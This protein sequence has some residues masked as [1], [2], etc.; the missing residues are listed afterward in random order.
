MI[1]Q[2]NK[3]HIVQLLNRTSFTLFS[4]NHQT[5]FSEQPHSYQLTH[6]RCPPLEFSII[7]TCGHNYQLSVNVINATNWY[8]NSVLSLSPMDISNQC[9][10]CHSINVISVTNGYFNSV[11]LLSP[12]SINQINVIIV[13]CIS[14]QCY[15]CHPW[16]FQISAIIVTNIYI[17]VQCNHCH[18]AIMCSTSP[19]STDTVIADAPPLESSIIITCDHDYQLS[20]Q[21]NHCH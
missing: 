3:L 21:C 9:N 16:I 18:W 5:S 8:P 4:S 7:I 1:E 14:T 10:Y 11:Q 13:I 17:P 20:S 19:A 15:H 2:L 12:I 6:C